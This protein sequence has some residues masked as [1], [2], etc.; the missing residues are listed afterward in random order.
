MNNNENGYVNMCRFYN[1]CGFSSSGM[2]SLEL[3][4]TYLKISDSAYIKLHFSNSCENLSEEMDIA[5][6]CHIIP[7]NQI[8]IEF[9]KS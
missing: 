1:V 2:I 7:S 9:Y 4:I 3:P 6:H 5:L 8:S